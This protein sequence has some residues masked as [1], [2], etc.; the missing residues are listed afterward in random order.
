LLQPL[1]V[2][3]QAWQVFSLDF[4]EG[5]PK[6]DQ[7]NAILVVVDKFN[8]YGHFIPLHHPFTTM[9]IAKVYLDNVYR[10]HGLPQAIISDRDPIFTSN[11]WQHLFKLT[12]IKLFMS[13]AYHPQMDGQT[14]RL[15]QCLEGFLHCTGTW[16]WSKWLPV[17]EYWYN[18]AYHSTLGQSPFEILYGHSPRHFGIANLQLCSVP[19]LEQW[20]KERELL[21]RIV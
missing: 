20:L 17:A 6:S 18:T 15:N 8:K 21:T 12:D 2:P 19:D 9:Q 5:L 1:P 16:Q 11:V 4:V 7:Y 3:T 14:K 13:S 10:H